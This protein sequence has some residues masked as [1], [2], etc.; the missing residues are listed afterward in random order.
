MI[1]KHVQK[2][3]FSIDPSKTVYAHCVAQDGA[4]GAGIAKQF[5]Q[6][7]PQLRQLFQQQNPKI[8]DAI[9]V[10]TDD[11]IIYNLVTKPVSYQPPT[12]HNA[13]AYALQN[14][15]YQ[16][17]SRGEQ[18]VAMPLIGAGLDRLNWHKTQEVMIDVFKDTDIAIGIAHLDDLSQYMN[19]KYEPYPETVSAVE[20]FQNQKHEKANQ[21]PPL[22]KSDGY[23]FNDHIVAFYGYKSPLS[24]MYV[25]NE[26]FMHKG[27]PFFSSEAAF[28]WEKAM[29]FGDQNMANFMLQNSNKP[30][31]CKRAGRNPI[32]GFSAEL[33][34]EKRVELMKEIL[35]NKF[36]NPNSIQHKV[37]F[38]TGERQLIEASPR[39]FDWGAGKKKE[40]LVSQNSPAYVGSYPGK[41]LM[42]QV[43]TEVRTDIQKEYLLNQSIKKPTLYIGSVRDTQLTNYDEIWG[44][45]RSLSQSIKQSLD[46][47]G[48]LIE[49]SSLSPS[50]QLLN[51]YLSLKDNNNW[52]EQ[53]FAS[54]YVPQYLYE[55]ASNPQAVSDM[56]SLI[57]ESEKSI[58]AFCYCGN[59]S[60]CHRSIIAGIVQGAGKNV[61]GVAKDYSTYYNQFNDV[62]KNIHGISFEDV[63]TNSKQPDIIYQQ[64]SKNV[65]P[66]YKIALTGHR[67]K[68][69]QTV[70]KDKYNLNDPTYEKLYQE[71]RNHA[72]DK[73]QEYGHITIISGMALGAD[74]VWANIAVNM[75]QDHGHEKVKFEAHVPIESHDAK[76]I[77]PKSRELYRNLLSYA[78]E[79][80]LYAPI[81]S[82]AAMQIRDKGMIDRSDEVIACYDGHSIHKSGTY[83]A[84]KDATNKDKN[85]HFTQPDYF[86]PDENGQRPNINNQLFAKQTART[87]YDYPDINYT[88]QYEEHNQP[89][90]F[91]RHSPGLAKDTNDYYMKEDPKPEIKIPESLKNNKNINFG[92]G[93]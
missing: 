44:T 63:L 19:V 57:N 7:Y 77:D 89:P 76:W 68:Y 21:F 53:T 34:N 27:L 32:E 80:V 29:L 39:D 37:L 23:E 72:E 26:P 6:K 31:D 3:L 71:L 65:I 51:K 13:L 90:Y 42:G 8:G 87:A 18:Y 38:A 4:M 16:M 61:E 48:K 11:A 62:Y 85:I 88:D 15:K 24:N 17:K 69:F 33:W 25:T 50:S 12:D 86:L 79:K 46:K 82:G 78:D 52:N 47:N 74:T 40:D 93:L 81:Y 73:L 5:T 45:V 28:H 70:G 20:Y 30:V 36:S 10:E 66:S 43:L 54:E 35:T 49:K 91:D 83:N 56:V 2:D 41:N 75:K 55:Q 67:P 60:I 84:I 14:M 9:K 22:D 1:I 92:F 64:P 59:E 58:S